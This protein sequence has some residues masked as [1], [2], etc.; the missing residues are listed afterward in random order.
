SEDL[1][2]GCLDR[3]VVKR[4]GAQIGRVEIGPKRGDDFV[5]REIE[6]LFGPVN[7]Q[8]EGKLPFVDPVA[9]ESLEFEG[10]GFFR[11]AVDRDA[12][13]EL[14]RESSFPALAA[15][16][17]SLLFPGDADVAVGEVFGRFENDVPLSGDGADRLEYGGAVGRSDIREIFLDELGESRLRH[18]PA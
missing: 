16:G 13:E 17:L 4:D 7:F 5:E 11:T 9:E 15:A 2:G 18:A 6:G 14:R 8:L 12:E 3:T 10:G 1:G